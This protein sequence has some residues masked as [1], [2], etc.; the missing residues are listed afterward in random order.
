MIMMRCGKVR[1]GHQQIE[2]RNFH[3]KFDLNITA[4]EQE[5][6]PHVQWEF[7]DNHYSG[8]SELPRRMDKH[9]YNHSTEAQQHGEQ[10]PQSNTLEGCVD[11]LL[12]LAQSAEIIAQSEDGVAGMHTDNQ[13]KGS[14]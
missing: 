11:H 10:V 8:F 2:F 9:K 1:H 14:Y 12:I 5:Q 3:D 7:L 4:P 13:N 6:Q